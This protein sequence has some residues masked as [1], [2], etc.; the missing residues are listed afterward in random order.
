MGDRVQL[1]QLLQ[2]LITNALKF[3]DGPR[4]H[5]WVQADPAATGMVQ[6]SVAD[7]G[8]GIDPT[9]RER[10]FE[11]F[12]R[13]HDRETY[14]GTGIGLA[15]CRK[16]VERHG[17]RIWVDEREGGGTVF[18]FTLPPAVAE[19]EP[20]AGLTSSAVIEEAAPTGRGEV[21]HEELTRP[22]QTLV[23]RMAESKATAPD[24]SLT[25]EAEPAH[26][27]V[28]YAVR[29]AALALRDFPRVN[30]AYRDGRFESYSRVNIGVAMAGP[31]A[32]V[33][34]TVLDAD[35]K[36]AYEIAA[37]LRV[38]GERVARGHDRRS[39]ALGRDVH[40]LEPARAPLHADPEPAAGGD[41]RG[42]GRSSR[43]RS[44]ATAPSWRAT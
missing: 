1:E 20:A 28:E 35:R 27:G 2:N 15:I 43:A 24:F 10:V 21:S 17:G 11:M 33:V 3:R 29:A 6:I 25:L 14:E 31:D 12:Q 32:L 30:G 8:I 7:G 18:R 19:V 40:G 39:G 9:H 26:A 36:G 5:V 22:Q 37:E 34:P 23:R 13:L 44:C 16:I 4:A 42:R 41:P 38:L